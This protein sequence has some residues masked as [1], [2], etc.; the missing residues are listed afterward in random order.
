MCLEAVAACANGVPAEVAYKRG[1]NKCV[2]G[3]RIMCYFVCHARRA[4]TA[5]V[6]LA[7]FAT[8]I[9]IFTLCARLPTCPSGWRGHDSK[10]YGLLEGETAAEQAFQRCYNQS[11]HLANVTE[12]EAGELRKMARTEHPFWV[13][14][15]THPL[16]ISQGSLPS[17]NCTQ[18]NYT[19]CF[20]P[21]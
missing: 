8:L 6:C 5:L 13:G 9:I 1:E 14:N 11:Y 4:R 2:A 3:S 17:Q 12:V 10:C 20:V 7:L 18:L 15:G 16:C 21:L 19:M